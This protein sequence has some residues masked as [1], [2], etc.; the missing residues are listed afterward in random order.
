MDSKSRRE[1]DKT[2]ERAEGKAPDLHFKI[3]LPLLDSFC[4]ISQPLHPSIYFS[5]SSDSATLL[6]TD[7]SSLLFVLA[8]FN[9]L[10]CLIF[11]FYQWSVFV[12]L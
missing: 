7:A 5:P 9:V 10:L 1:R 6:V 8:F 11:S 3:F 2:G 4:S 12:S